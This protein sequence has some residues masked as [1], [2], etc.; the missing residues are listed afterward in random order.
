MF[1]HMHLSAVEAGLVDFV[2]VQLEGL[3]AS[4]AYDRTAAQVLSIAISYQIS[5]HERWPQCLKR[6]PST[7]AGSDSKASTIVGHTKRGTALRSCA[8]S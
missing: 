2:T 4:Q 6:L 1:V 7:V 3:E 5:S 8:G